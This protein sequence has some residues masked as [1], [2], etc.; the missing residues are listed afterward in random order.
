MNN[1]FLIRSA[2]SDTALAV[3]TLT[4]GAYPEDGLSWY[5]HGKKLVTELKTKLSKENYTGGE[6]EQISYAQCAL[7]DEVAL[8]YLKGSEREIW[9]MEPLQVHFFQ[10]YHAGDVLCN[11]IEELCK[12]SQP[13]TKVAEAYL[14]VLNLGFRGRYVLD[15]AEAN[16]WR[17][18]LNKIVPDVPVDANTSDGQFFYV[19]KKGTPIKGAFRINPMWVFVFCL[20][21]A[22]ISYFLFDY[23]LNGLAEQIQPKV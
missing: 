1:Q 14:S 19:D 4:V 23:Y 20:L 10:S 21:L 5:E 7:L 16:K 18:S 2:L 11:R 3:S 8:K 13:N 12:D 22:I 15:E 17:E 9:E 6:I